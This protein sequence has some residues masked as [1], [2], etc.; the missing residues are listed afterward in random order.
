MSNQV[1]VNM[2]GTAY[3]RTVPGQ[4]KERFGPGQGILVP[5]GLARSLGLPE[6]PEVGAV[7]PADQALAQP[8]TGALD[9]GGHG[10]TG[11]QNQPSSWPWGR[12]DETQVALLA[13]AG[14]TTPEQVRRV[15]DEEL[16]GLGGGGLFVEDLREATGPYEE[17]ARELESVDGI[18]PELAAALDEQGIKTLAD[19]RAAS[20]EALLAVP[21][22]GKTSLKRLREATKE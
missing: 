10:A 4:P 15:S 19:F 11:N 14:Y 20:D 22:I 13:Q 5:E 2:R 7:E 17:P 6:V 12:L 1:R 21:G 3:Y 16:A 8:Q 9:A 18:G